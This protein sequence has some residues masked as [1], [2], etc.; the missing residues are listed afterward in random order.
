M[1]GFNNVPYR[2]IPIAMLAAPASIS[3]IPMPFG[4]MPAAFASCGHTIIHWHLVY[5]PSHRTLHENKGRTFAQDRGCACVMPSCHFIL[6]PPAGSCHTLALFCFFFFCIV[7]LPTY[8]TLTF[9]PA[10]II[11]LA[12]WWTF[13]YQHSQTWMCLSC[14]P[15][16]HDIFPLTTTTSLPPH[17]HL[18]LGFGH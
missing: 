8:K 3:I 6:C 7:S 13:T 5:L 2:L 18:F 4:N 14:W 9:L 11:P 1:T 15:W 16:R 12:W 17:T 10:T